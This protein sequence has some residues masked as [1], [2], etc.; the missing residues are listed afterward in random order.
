MLDLALFDRIGSLL[1]DDLEELL[2]THL[3]GV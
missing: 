1:L 3:G 2:N